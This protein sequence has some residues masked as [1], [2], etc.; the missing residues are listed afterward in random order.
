[1]SF[2]PPSYAH[3]KLQLFC[4]V[5]LLFLVCVPAFAQQRPL[6]TVEAETLPPGTMRAQVGFDFLQDVSYPLSGL[7]GDQTSVGVIN[8]RLGVGKMV[9]IQLEGAVRHFLDAKERISGPVTPQL[10][11]SCT[12]PTGT[13]M[14]FPGC[15]SNDVGDFSLFTKIRIIPETDRRPA[16]AF[17][18]GFQMPNSNQIRGIGSNTSNLFAEMILQKHLGKLNLFGNAG[19]AI[20]QSPTQNFSQNDVLTYGVAFIYAAHR[21]VNVVG[22]VAGRYS[23]RKLTPS[24]FGT[25]SRSQGRFGLQI[26]AG[27]LQWDFAGIAGLT[28]NDA[29]TGFTFGISKDVPLFDYGT[30]K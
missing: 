13:A 28:R 9:E 23:S 26:L 21:R 25:E 16:L 19:V 1:M 4:L 7:S 2:Q 11:G 30:V 27:G 15:S 5:G 29:K 12:T 14:P 6:R 24:L 18:F 10:S 17:R 22:E 3:R 8:V 20:L